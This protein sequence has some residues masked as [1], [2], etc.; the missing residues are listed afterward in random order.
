MTASLRHNPVTLRGQD[1][2]LFLTLYNLPTID[3][4]KIQCL[5]D[6]IFFIS[7]TKNKIGFYTV[8]ITVWC[9][10]C[11]KYCSLGVND[12]HV[13]FV[14]FNYTQLHRLHVLC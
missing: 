7:I 2:L 8:C 14:F 10:S 9:Y 5:L 1:Y 11:Y 12:G 3:S 6:S 13:K 4:T